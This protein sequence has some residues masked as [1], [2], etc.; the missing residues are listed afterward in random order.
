MYQPRGQ[1]TQPCLAL[2][3]FQ[4][5]VLYKM[6]QI[7]SI[8]IDAHIFSL[9]VTVLFRVKLEFTPETLL[10]LEFCSYLS[11]VVLAL[12]KLEF[13]LQN[14]P[15][16]KWPQSIKFLSISFAKTMPKHKCK[17]HCTKMGLTNLRS[18]EFMIATVTN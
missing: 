17:P 14:V 12:P 2:E 11:Q 1:L 13:F 9:Y 8:P 18:N 4:M 3:Q 6:V 7:K 15:I 16:L 5:V 10:G